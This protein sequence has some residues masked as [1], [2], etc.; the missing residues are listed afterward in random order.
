MEDLGEIE[1]AL[2]ELTE[3]QRVRE[4]TAALLEIARGQEEGLAKV[5]D[6]LRGLEEE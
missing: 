4:L 1:R 5:S 2:E 3:D 6:E